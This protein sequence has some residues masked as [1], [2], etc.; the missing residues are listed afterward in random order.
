VG[1]VE[2]MKCAFMQA[3]ARISRSVVPSPYVVGGEHLAKKFIT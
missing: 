3:A 1:T 2:V